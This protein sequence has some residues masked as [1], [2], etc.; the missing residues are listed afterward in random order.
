MAD[1]IQIGDI[2]PRIH[3]TGDGATVAFTYP[4]PVFQDADIAVYVDGALQTLTTH[5]AVS[6]AGAS[7]GGSV[8]FVSP[9]ENGAAVALV[10]ELTIQR[11]T[12]F[13]SSGEFRAKVINDELDYQTAALQQLANKIER[14]VRLAS[15]DPASAMTLPDASDRADHVLAF[16]GDGKLTTML[17]NSDTYISMSAFAGTL[18]DDVDASAARATL[19]AQTHDSALDTISALTPAEGQALVYTGTVWSA[20]DISGADQVARDMAA[21]ALAYT[22]AQNDA[23]SITGGV[24]IFNLSD[25]FESDSLAT[26]TGATYDASGDFYGTSSGGFTE[27]EPDGATFGNMTSQGGLAAAFDDSSPQ[28]A[29]SCAR[30]A[31]TGTVAYAGKSFS[32]GQAITQVKVF[33]SSDLGFSNTPAASRTIDVY[34]KNGAPSSATDGTLIGTTGAFSDANSA[35]T[36]TVS[37]PGDSYT[38]VW[39]VIDPGGGNHAWFSEIEYHADT[40]PANVTLAPTAATLNTADPTDVVGYFVLDPLQSVTFGTDI[41]GKISIDGGTTW[42]AGSWAK[43]GDIGSAGEELYRLEA[44]VSGQTGAS[45]VYQITT[46]NNKDVRLHDCVGLVAIY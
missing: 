33:S 9:P 26:S 8:T 21:S 15:S 38:H 4:F 36:K 24:G 34:G 23:I 1:H 40:V 10:R 41:V 32:V 31:A 18:L 37:L 2:A 3:Y 22:L 19:G 29:T 16:D 45:L 30:T 35:Q 17:P 14:S 46:A 27:V 5:Y 42:A 12:D 39:A 43:V 25:D 20:A 13:Q 44:D 7:S 6:G 11:L 28:A